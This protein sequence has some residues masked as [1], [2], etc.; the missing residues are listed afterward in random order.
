MTVGVSFFIK[1]EKDKA[2]FILGSGAARF[3]V[4][5]AKSVAAGKESR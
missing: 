2:T 4:R 5:M 3:R 1:R